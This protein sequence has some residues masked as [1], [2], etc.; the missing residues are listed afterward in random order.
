MQT[1][2][3]L[4]TCIDDDFQYLVITQSDNVIL[5]NRIPKMHEGIGWEFSKSKYCNIT[6]IFKPFYEI[7]KWDVGYWKRTGNCKTDGLEVWV[8]V[9]LNLG[10]AYPTEDCIPKDLNS[11]IKYLAKNCNGNVFGYFIKPQI[12]FGAGIWFTQDTKADW[13]YCEDENSSLM[14]TRIWDSG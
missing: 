3:L 10:Y 6:S 5:L 12:G 13:L 4:P 11:K 9:K 14:Q 8:F 2:I 1:K 7:P